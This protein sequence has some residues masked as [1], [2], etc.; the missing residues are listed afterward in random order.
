MYR[1]ALY[2]LPDDRIILMRKPGFHLAPQNYL[3]RG[4]LFNMVGQPEVDIVLQ[5]IIFPVVFYSWLCTC[6]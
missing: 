3:F 2:N 1:R 5:L 4:D 6:N